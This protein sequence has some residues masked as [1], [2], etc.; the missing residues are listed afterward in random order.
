MHRGPSSASNVDPVANNSVPDDA[1]V[2]IIANASSVPALQDNEIPTDSEFEILRLRHR[3][4]E[5]ECITRDRDDRIV[6]ALGMLEDELSFWR[7]YLHDHVSETM[8]GISRR[9]GRLESA[10][11]YL[12]EKGSRF[13]PPLPI[14]PAWKKKTTLPQR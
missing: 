7:S 6:K 9:V 14:P 11:E 10:L 8:G 3:V 12:K 4:A 13:Y 2:N 5:L 1:E